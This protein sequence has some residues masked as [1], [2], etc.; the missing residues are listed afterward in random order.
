M[1][2]FPSQCLV[3]CPWQNY[4]QCPSTSHG[5][6][7]PVSAPQYIIDFPLLI[8]LK[9]KSQKTQHKNHCPW[10]YP[11]PHP[12]YPAQSHPSVPPQ[13][14]V[15]Y[16]LN[17]S[18]TSI[19]ATLMLKEKHVLKRNNPAVECPLGSFINWLL[20]RLFKFSVST[21]R[22]LIYEKIY[23][24]PGYDIALGELFGVLLEF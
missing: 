16:R 4:P 24:N 17:I 11:A 18:T 13:C 2:A 22:T 19:K 8:L 10:Q 15:L 7:T 5:S 14:L 3:T 12:Q 6:L 20:V 23:I 21:S 9:Q 1:V